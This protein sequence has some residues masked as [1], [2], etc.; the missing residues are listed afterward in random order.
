[1]YGQAITN[2]ACLRDCFSKSNTSDSVSNS[3]GWA[4]LIKDVSTKGTCDDGNN[5][6]AELDIWGWSEL[7]NNCVLEE[8]E[9]NYDYYYD[10]DYDY[11]FT[12][13]VIAN[14]TCSNRTETLL[15]TEA[16]MSSLAEQPNIIKNTVELLVQSSC[17][18]KLYEESVTK[19]RKSEQR[20][21]L[22]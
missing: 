21:L 6:A 22:Q 19:R 10:S 16:C 13:Q 9:Y 17:K 2:P 18:T 3:S 4:S 1:M 11:S 14:G 7:E 5:P 12:I 20:A 15:Q 8:V